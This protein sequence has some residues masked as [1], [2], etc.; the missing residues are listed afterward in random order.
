M[1]IFRTNSER[2]NAP[3]GALGSRALRI[4]FAL[5]FAVAVLSPVGV[6]FAVVWTAPPITAGAAPTE[7]L[8]PA[9]L[10]PPPDVQPTSL[11][12]P[13]FNVYANTISGIVPCPLCELPPR[14]YVPNSMAGTVDVIDPRTFTVIDHYRVGSIPHHIAPAWDMSALYVDNEGSSSLT[15]LDIKTGKPI[16]QINIPFPYNLYFTPDG[17]K[18]VD[19]V[20][21][22]QRIEFRD[23][24][25]G[26][27]LLKSV[28]IPWPG[29][30]HLDF[31]ADGSYLMISTEY[32]GIVAKVDVNTMEMVGYVRVG[33]LPIDIKVSP[34]GS[35]FYV[36]NQGRM[37]VSVVDPIAMQEIQ[38]IPTGRGAHGLQVSRDTKSLYV[39]NRLEGSI[40]VIDFATRTVTAKWRIPGG[41]SP[42][43]LQLSPDG[44]QLWA[45]GR[46]NATV[47][48][49]DTTTGDLL[50]RIPVGSEDHGLTYFP[51]V[52]Q[53]SL[54]HNGVYR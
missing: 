30:D 1:K 19:V 22:L 11:P 18:A 2:K 10:L 49:F 32:S 51:N 33:G 16:D 45:S 44:T 14:V 12:A 8:Q 4:L 42:D 27:A 5:V 6:V 53:H 35:V 29:A 46:Y 52:G 15:V 50:A 37:G 24:R 23:W 36:T 31:S 40:S 25:H 34:D 28:A 48:V 47:Y 3:G 38:F 41:G 26:W 17:T 7:D 13:A 39:S 43:M 9:R 54:G 20:E 21:R